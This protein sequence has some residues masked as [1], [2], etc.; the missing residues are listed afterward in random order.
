M[1]TT[2]P[3]FDYKAEQLSKFL[4]S[5]D[6]FTIMLKNVD[7]IHYAPADKNSFL[8]WLSQHHVE[9]LKA[10]STVKSR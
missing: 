6:M 2:Y 1:A 7:I 10:A 9:N 4:A 3:G 8:D 5:A